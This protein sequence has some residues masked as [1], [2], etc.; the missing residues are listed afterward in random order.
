M[1]KII[2]ILM[3]VGMLFGMTACGEN[4]SFGRFEYS[5][6][7][8][9]P[10]LTA[11][12]DIAEKEKLSPADNLL[13]TDVAAQDKTYQNPLLDPARGEGE[14]FGDPFV[15]RYN[16]KYYFYHTASQLNCWESED[17]VNWTYVGA[18]TENELFRGSWAP[19]V[20][21]Y[22]GL[23]YM[24]TTG[25]DGEGDY[26]LT[27]ESPTGPFEISASYINTN[28]DTDIF[29]DDNGDWYMYFPYT[30][31]TIR[32][33]EMSDTLTPN[34]FTLTDLGLNVGDGA[35]TEGPMVIK[36]KDT[37]FMTYC[38]GG[39]SGPGYQIYY[40][41]S[42][43]D[44]FNFVPGEN[45]PI[46]LNTDLTTYPGLGHSS[47][48]TGPNLDSLYK[49]YHSMPWREQPRTMMIDPLYINGDYMQAMGPT[50]STQQAPDM[51]D[52]YSRFDSAESLTGW[53]SMNAEIVDSQLKLPAGGVVISEKGIEGDFTA[54]YNFLSIEDV[55]GS[56]EAFL[57]DYGK[58]GAI[59]DYTD[60]NNY[61]AAYIDSES[62]TLNVVF[63]V[64]GKETSY[65]DDLIASFDD[66]FDYTKL[67]KL[68][69]KKYGTKYR[70]LFNDITICEYESSLTGGSIGVS[71]LSGAAKIGFVGIEGDVWHSSYKELYKP[72]EGEFG[73]LLCVENQLNI[74]EYNNR[75]YLSVK[76]GESYNYYINAEA[77]TNYD[78]GMKYR[79]AEDISFEVYFNGNLIY[80]GTAPA[81]DADRSE[82]FRGLNLNQ[83]Y[84]VLTFKF[85]EG[86]ADIFNYE[87]ITS[88][89][90]SENITFDLAAPLYS[91]SENRIENGKISTP[92]FAKVF[93]GNREWADYS[94]SATFTANGSFL[95][96]NLIFRATNESL[97]PG[98]SFAECKEYYLGYSVSLFNDGKESYVALNKDNYGRTEL[99]RVNVNVPCDTPVELKAEAVGENIKVYLN[100]ELVIEYADPD[101]FMKGAVGFSNV[102]SAKVSDLKAE[103]LFS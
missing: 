91:E 94:V 68:T 88:T 40:A 103:P 46:L 15:L 16:G 54:E 30:G 80:Q 56:E 101:P 52:I 45:N 71:C 76:G 2:S 27:S 61:G 37:Y 13:L 35:W 24:T 86:S 47:M 102:V 32:G 84:G 89:N 75:E 98:Y 18:C 38:G 20:R 11:T 49:I 23:F 33:L 12:V 99:V 74:K 57:P 92:A 78:F 31:D 42:T 3:V 62:S 70:F 48:V 1:R 36:H 95:S 51:P 90:I 17:L 14:Q 63:T 67:Q 25:P 19:E 60:A 6:I 50:L 44:M 64:D 87:F 29:I 100:G 59:F 58:V 81:S 39:V 65:K 77:T 66:Q 82:V 96:P 22:N 93:Y 97:T 41:T 4:S 43:G 55:F 53:T 79:A 9:I 73:A 5:E 69:V 7:N 85:T 28:F 26:I 8:N 10:T 83:G 34:H 72:V 21:Y